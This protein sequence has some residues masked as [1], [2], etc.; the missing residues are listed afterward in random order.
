MHRGPVSRASETNVRTRQRPRERGIITWQ[1][2]TPESIYQNGAA[3][4]HA[5]HADSH[6]RGIAPE[7]MPLTAADRAAAT[8]FTSGE[9]CPM[10]SAAH[11][12][13][14]LGRSRSDPASARQRRC[15]PLSY[16]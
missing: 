3:V 4:T 5:E 1:P 10:C 16:D 11:A 12:W 15:P 9:H 2:V 14:G 6:A 8:V 7:D 13:A